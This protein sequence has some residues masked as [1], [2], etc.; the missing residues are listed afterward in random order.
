MLLIPFLD[1]L[2]FLVRLLDF[3]RF[4]S[5][6]YQIAGFSKLFQVFKYLATLTYTKK[7]E[8]GNLKTNKYNIK[9][10]KNY[11]FKKTIFTFN[12]LTMFF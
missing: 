12:K 4:F 9:T 11:K 1:F 5:L 8:E 3:S 10:W 6:N 2:R 7:K